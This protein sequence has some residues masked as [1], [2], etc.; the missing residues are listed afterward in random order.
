MA[1]SINEEVRKQANLKLLQKSDPT[2]SDILGSATHVVLYNFSQ[3]SQSWE[4]SNVEGS[5]FL[6]STTSNGYILVI[7]NRNAPENYKIQLTPDFQL[8]NSIP[9][10][11]FKQQQDANVV[12]RGIWFPND[13]E[14]ESMHGLLTQVL[15]VLKTAPPTPTPVVV[16]TGAAIAALLSPMSLGGGSA[17]VAVAQPTTPSSTSYAASLGVTPTTT[18]P[19]TTSTSSSSGGTPPLRQPSPS[20]AHAPMLDKK[21]LQLALLSLI[22]DERFLDLLHSQY[23]KVAHARASRNPRDE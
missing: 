18:N 22:Q 23:L 11:I 13:D 7:L 16:D 15:F 4:K 5:L 9:Y 19:R 3:Q 12:I 1:L 17:A 10:L 14:R 2:I 6:T 20:S 8:Q 21:S